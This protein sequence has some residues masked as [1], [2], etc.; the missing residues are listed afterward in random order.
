MA[1][2]PAG[3]QAALRILLW[4][5]RK[6]AQKNRPRD[7]KAASRDDVP[8]RALVPTMHCDAQLVIET[9]GTLQAFTAMPAEVL[10]LGGSKSPAYLKTSLDALS[11]VLPHARRVEL[12][13]CD[14]LHQTTAASQNAP[15]TSCD[16]SSQQAEPGS[17]RRATSPGSPPRSAPELPSSA[18]RRT[19]QGRRRGAPHRRRCRQAQLAP[20][21]RP[22]ACRPAPRQRSVT[23]WRNAQP[24]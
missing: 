12:H 1:G 11:S 10:L 13:G 5:L 16:R 14:H 8:L 7:G 15:P 2:Q 21:R 18:T 9:E 3:R 17:R 6:A 19:R 23:S 22:R 24:A 20:G 4:P